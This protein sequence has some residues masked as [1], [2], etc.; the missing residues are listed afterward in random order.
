MT[1]FDFN[2]GVLTDW[3]LEMLENNLE[4][5]ILVGDGQ[6]PLAGGWTGGEPGDGDFVSYVTLSTGP[7]RKQQA[8][9]PAIGRENVSWVCSYTLSHT[10]ALRQ[11]VDWTADKVRPAMSA[12]RGLGPM[13]NWTI[14]L[15]DYTVLGP[16]TRNSSIDPPVWEL[17]DSVDLWLERAR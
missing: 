15:V 17:S 2:R 4:P 16:V 13:E 3:L 10:G 12:A 14:T 1:T 9:R 6:A 11:Q 8:S 5:E 7:A